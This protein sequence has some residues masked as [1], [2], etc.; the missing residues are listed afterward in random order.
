M[1][2]SVE[3]KK[4][5]GSIFILTLMI[6]PFS[7]CVRDY[8]KT[9]S[10]SGY[11]YVVK[12]GD[13][14]SSV[15]QVHRMSVDELAELNNLDKSVS[16]KEGLVLFVP[17]EDPTKKLNQSKE[18]K[19]GD[20]KD[21]ALSQKKKTDQHTG[22]ASGKTGIAKKP[23]ITKNDKSSLPQENV[24]IK[25][26]SKDKITQGEH[27]KS[28]IASRKEDGV[29]K[30]KFIWPLKGK[31]IS[32]YGPQANG[33]FYNGIRI[34]TKI[35]ASVNAS[36]GGHVIFSALLK[37]YGETIIIKHENNYATVYTHLTKRQVRVD[38]IVKR[39]EKIALIIPVS[40]G[41][42]FFDF[43]IRYKNKAKDPLLFLS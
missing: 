22:K 33:M 31:V 34:E 23:D 30:G 19:L 21:D 26:E 9:E 20:K 6:I 35:E 7:G 1:N 41:V 32:Q 28:V 11:Y 36:A 10:S 39:G 4:V 2:Y 8:V 43:E 16:I 38:Q 12:T 3:L 40:T 5:I 15:A 27:S 13:T 42:A 37:D 25:A 14:L 17:R 24:K 29:Q 18:D